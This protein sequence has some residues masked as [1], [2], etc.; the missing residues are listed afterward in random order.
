MSTKFDN[1]EINRVWNKGVIVKGYDEALFRQDSCGAWIVKNEYGKTSPFGWEIDHVYPQVK[2][3]DDNFINLR[4]MH[5]ENNLS[6]SDDYPNYDSAVIA[7]DNRNVKKVGHFT[8]NNSLRNSLEQLY[9]I[10]S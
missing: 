3:G 10:Q 8:V 4:P 2:G 1:N 9:H 5:W 7:E 6:K